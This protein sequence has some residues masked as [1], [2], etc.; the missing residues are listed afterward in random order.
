MTFTV[1]NR[2]TVFLK[3][4]KLDEEEDEEEEFE[5]EKR[6]VKMMGVAARNGRGGRVRARWA[7]D[8]PL[9]GVNVDTKQKDTEK[10]ETTTETCNAPPSGLSCASST[11]PS[12]INLSYSSACSSVSS[13]AP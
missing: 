8:V 4:E 10:E 3:D 7:G 11:Q 9:G 12:L 5:G 6:A 1:D 2:S 13:A